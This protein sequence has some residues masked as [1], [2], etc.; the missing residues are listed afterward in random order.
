[1]PR[2][3]IHT[4]K[5]ETAHRIKKA[6]N[7]CDNAVGALRDALT[8]ATVLQGDCIGELIRDAAEL[9]RKCARLADVIEQDAK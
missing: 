4:M 3:Q 7:K 2:L 5:S 6:A 8:F 1:M 9:K